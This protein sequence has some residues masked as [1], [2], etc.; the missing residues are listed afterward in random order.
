[1]VGYAQSLS[2]DN[3]ICA[4]DNKIT[5]HA[6]LTQIFFFDFS[7]V[8][9][10]NKCQS[11][12]I[13]NSQKRYIW[14]CFKILEKNKEF[15]IIFDSLIPREISN[16][17][18]RMKLLNLTYIIANILNVKYNNI[19]GRSLIFVTFAKAMYAKGQ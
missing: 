17:N 4:G 19:N 11:L 1:M 8:F 6:K 2:Q 7:A 3:Q 13:I 10:P 18:Q 12:Y 5:I 9:Q 14:F 16:L 15:S